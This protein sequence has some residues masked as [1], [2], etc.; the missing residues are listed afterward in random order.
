V[1][2]WFVLKARIIAIRAA[3]QI[4]PPLSRLGIAIPGLVLFGRRQFEPAAWQ[5]PFFRPGNYE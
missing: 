2:I 4:A 5:P 1:A 3:F